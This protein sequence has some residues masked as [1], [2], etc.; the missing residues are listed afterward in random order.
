MVRA[1]AKMHRTTFIDFD[2]FQQMIPLQD[3]HMS[4]TYFLKS[5]FLNCIN[6][7]S[8]RASTNM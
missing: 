1:S 3:L 8:V 6:L 7:E 5:P 2:I 4:L